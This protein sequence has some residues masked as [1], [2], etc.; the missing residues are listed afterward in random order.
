MSPCRRLTRLLVVLFTLAFAPLAHAQIDTG[1]IV[2]RV[3]DDSGA[4]LPGVTVDAPRRT[5][6]A[7]RRRR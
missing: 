7:S 2:G 6:P 3:T 1:A 4:V 5:A